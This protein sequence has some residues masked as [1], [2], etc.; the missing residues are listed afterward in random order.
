[1][2]DNKCQECGNDRFWNK[3]RTWADLTIKCKWCGH[4]QQEN[5]PTMFSPSL[6][7]SLDHHN[8]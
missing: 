2:T 6:T 8:I 5:T 7:E 3:G 4:T 1:M